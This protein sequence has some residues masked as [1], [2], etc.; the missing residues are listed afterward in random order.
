MTRAVGDDKGTMGVVT[1]LKHPAIPY[2]LP[3][4][5]FI[6]FLAIR[7]VLPFGP[8]WEYP[9]R[10][11]ITAAALAVFSRS[12]IAL[13]PACPLA[14]AV[15]GT[16]VFVVWVA[17]DVL[18]PAY[19]QHWL[20]SN[21]ITGTPQSSLPDSLR[22]NVLWLLFRIG[23]TAL[24]VPI[25][26]ELFWRGWLMRYLVRP[27]FERVRLGTYTAVSFWVT[28]LLFASEHG[29]Y[30]DVGVVAGTCYGWWMIRTRSLADCILAHG[31]TNLWLACYVVG[32]A[33][34][35]YWL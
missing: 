30:W 18:W 10:V 34:W 16:A 13:R 28:V 20:L 35:Q 9:A 22:H 5:V 33:R 14:S 26:E 1:R 32:W 2:V 25:I 19:R 31:V 3:F 12:A 8:E 4:A 6:L 27:E 23:G 17:P 24:L 21:A 29:P 7:N 15:L 11:V